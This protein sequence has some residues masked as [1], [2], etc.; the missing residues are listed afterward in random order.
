M[1]SSFKSTHFADFLK[2]SRIIFNLKAK[3]KIGALEE[4]LDILI[5]QKLIKTESLF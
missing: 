4:L 1:I 5:K 3:D 2:P